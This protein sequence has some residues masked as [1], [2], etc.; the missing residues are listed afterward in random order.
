MSSTA[1]KEHDSFFVD[2]M[3]RGDH[4]YIKAVRDADVA[5]EAQCTF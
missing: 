5:G 4:I 3:V 2:Y 1:T